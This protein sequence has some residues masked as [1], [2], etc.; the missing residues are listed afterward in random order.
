M[1]NVEFAGGNAVWA[2]EG[3]SILH[4]LMSSGMQIV[5]SPWLSA[6]YQ[7]VSHAVM[8]SKSMKDPFHLAFSKHAQSAGDVKEFG[9]IEI[10]AGEP[11]DPGS[12][13]SGGSTVGTG[14]DCGAASG[15]APAAK[16][17]QVPA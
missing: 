11:E 2:V 17:S 8:T 13:R 16:P 15:Q 12:P 3:T 10:V 9:F 7:D 6:Y 5:K 4:M 14:S 1:H